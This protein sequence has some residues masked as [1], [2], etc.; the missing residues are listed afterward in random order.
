LKE[1]NGVKNPHFELAEGVVSEPLLPI[2]DQAR[3]DSPPCKN[4]QHLA[5]MVA[6][7]RGRLKLSREA[8]AARL[9]VS[10]GT[11]KNWW[12]GRTKPNKAFWK[13]LRLIGY[14]P[15]SPRSAA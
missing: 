13:Q 10:L 2:G 15:L 7:Y 3:Q 9:G 4:A 8:L 6:E 1:Q 11:L 5:E 12:F 14:M